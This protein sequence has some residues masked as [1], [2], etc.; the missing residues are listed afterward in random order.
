M[1]FPVFPRYDRATRIAQEFLLRDNII[2]FPI[3]PFI[4]IEKHKWGLITYAELAQKNCIHIT[5]IV[6]AFQSEDGFTMYDGVN[7]TIAY[8]DTVRSKGRIKFTLM[9]EIG[10]IML[11]HLVDYKETILMRNSL[12]DEKYNILEKETNAFARNILSPVIL[13][14]ELRLKSKEDIVY[15]FNVSETAASTRLKCITLDLKNTTFN[16]ANDLLKQFKGFIYSTRH[17]NYCSQCGYFF[18][19]KIAQYCPICGRVGLSKRGQ[20]K[21]I[22]SG[23]VL[24]E[25]EREQ[26]NQKCVNVETAYVENSIITGT[27]IVNK[28]AGTNTANNGFSESCGNLALD[29]ARYCYKCG[30]ETTF[31]QT[32]LLKSWDHKMKG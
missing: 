16:I 10:H 11:N 23:Y 13:V 2:S 19:R 7:Y 30:N 8:N 12:S 5:R 18:I 31:F 17:S 22:Y 24:N 4:I 25:K 3:N 28:C 26:L 21:I 1:E 6:K 20:K 9:H 32:G 29:N 14:D 15:Y 27:G